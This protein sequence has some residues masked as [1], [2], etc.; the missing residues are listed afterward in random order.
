MKQAAVINSQLARFPQHGELSEA[1][2]QLSIQLADGLV[3]GLY[4]Q[5]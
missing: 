2:R 3:S 4:I 1:L 5:G